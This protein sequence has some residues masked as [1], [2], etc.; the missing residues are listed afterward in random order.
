MRS[1]LAIALMGSCATAWAINP[2]GDKLPKYINKANMDVSVKPG[3]NFYRYANGTWL[4]NNPV[5]ASKT[6]WGSFDA[7]HEESVNRLHTLLTDAAAKA[8]SVSSL[9]KI[10]DYYASGMDTVMI[11][12]LGVQPLL[13]DLQRIDAIKDVNGLLNELASDRTQGLGN[14]LFGFSIQPD[15]K[16]VN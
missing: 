10:G 13:P 11:D 14:A 4:K 8:S 15:R 3:D 2:P 1:L 16:N 12:K 7:L 5:P 9:Q 6:R